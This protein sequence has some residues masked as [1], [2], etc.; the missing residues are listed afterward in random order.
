LFLRHWGSFRR[1]R[2]HRSMVVIPGDNDATQ[3][4]GAPR[5]ICRMGRAGCVGLREQTMKKLT[6][7]TGESSC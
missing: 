7:E 3:R 2:E 6:V 1:R 4:R 5:P